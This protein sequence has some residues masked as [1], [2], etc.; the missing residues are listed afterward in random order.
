MS[1]FSSVGRAF[2]CSGLL[3]SNCHL[4]DSGN[5]ES[6]SGV[7]VTHNPSKVELGVRFPPNA[8]I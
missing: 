1:E 8:N 6:V 5:L 3:I 7:V 2:D 4:F